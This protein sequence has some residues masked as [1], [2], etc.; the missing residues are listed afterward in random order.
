MK[1]YYEKLGFDFQKKS[2]ESL[3]DQ[4]I[5]E[6]NVNRANLATL[7][8]DVPS[9]LKQ[10]NATKTQSILS[11]A[12]Q[13]HLEEITQHFKIHDFFHHR[14]GIDNHY[15]ISKLERG[16]ELIKL[17]NIPKEE[18]IL[19]GDTDHDFEV[20]SD[21]GITCLLVADGHQSIER[22]SKFSSTVISGRRTF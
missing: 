8:H 15:A 21:L 5:R 4:F 6:Y 2:F 11:A 9:L 13:W 19:I 17:S 3:C 12:A 16:K 20:A 7:F 1:T 10:I 18:T 22:L 14:F